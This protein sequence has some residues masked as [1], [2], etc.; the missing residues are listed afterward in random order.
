MDEPARTGRAPGS[1]GCGGTF[2]GFPI[3]ALL[4]GGSEIPTFL[5]YLVEK[6]LTMPGAATVAASRHFSR[7]RA[8]SVPSSSVAPSVF[9]AT[10]RT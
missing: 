6:K 1:P 7:G 4:A 2:I 3:G 10:G 5:S 9:S 8:S